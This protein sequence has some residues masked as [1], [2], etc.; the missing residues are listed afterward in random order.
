MRCHRWRLIRM[1]FISK[2]EFFDSMQENN[3]SVAIDEA[4][5]ASEPTSSETDIQPTDIVKT[6]KPI[7]EKV[8]EKVEKA[9]A[10]STTVGD[11]VHT[12]TKNDSKADVKNQSRSGRIIKRKKYVNSPK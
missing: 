6:E 5:D 7:V 12:N 1:I 10:V 11:N 3:E 9:E 2:L 8:A 4:A